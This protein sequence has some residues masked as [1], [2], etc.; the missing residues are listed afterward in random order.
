MYAAFMAG[1]TLFLLEL[2]AR[3][4]F[5]Q[6]VSQL[7]RRASSRAARLGAAPWPEERPIA[8]GGGP[9]AGL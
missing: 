8:K 5:G 2:T 3:V 6:R 9:G 1:S 7:T 4:L